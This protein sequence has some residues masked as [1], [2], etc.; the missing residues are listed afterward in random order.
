KFTAIT[1]E[2]RVYTSFGLLIGIC[3]FDTAILEHDILFYAGLYDCFAGDI[4]HK[5]RFLRRYGIR[6]PTV[7]QC[8]VKRW[9]PSGRMAGKTR[10]ISKGQSN[11][12]SDCAFSVDGTAFAF[13]DPFSDLL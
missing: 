3:L 1:S 10:T 12:L 11:F 13:I 6:F 8:H 9:G 2:H 5:G 7:P 4:Y